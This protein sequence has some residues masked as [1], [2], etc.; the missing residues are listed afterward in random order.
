MPLMHRIHQHRLANGLWLVAEPIAEVQ[1]LAMSLLL[2][3]GVS[4]EPEHQQGAATMLSEMICRGAGGLDARAHSD[5]LD[6]L[7]VQRGT[8]V[9]TH[10]LRLSAAMIADKLPQALPLLMDMVR[11]PLLADDALEPTRDLSLQSLEALEDEPQQK[12][13]IALRRQHHPQPFGRSPMGRRE[14]LEAMTLD[15]VR[16]F[17]RRSFVPD[18]AVLSFAGKLD[19][20][21]LRERV[22]SLLGDWT[23]QLA[24]P[25]PTAPA[26]RGYY[27]ENAPSTQVHIGLAYDAPPET[28]PSS[29]LQRAAVA[30]L[31]GGMS[32]RLF[33]QVRERRGLV[34]SVFARYGSDRRRGSVFSY[35]G[36]T[37]PRAQE[38]LQVLTDELRGLAK[39][40]EPDEFQRAI[41][42]MKA[43]LVMQGES[44]S[45]R[46][47]AIA[48][49]QYLLDH[50]RT[51]E[52]VSAQVDALTLD[53]VV[54][55]VTEHPPGAM[56]TVT[57][58]PEPLQAL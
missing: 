17:W 49:D 8:G 41:V 37:A 2:P 23:G 25:E 39:G 21:E 18:G 10:H 28:D 54:R 58:G 26:T 50:P 48:A 29:M 46:A 43:G 15:H 20:T 44:T 56:T 9:D 32:G 7:G 6:H 52:E 51:L 13:F 47:G 5:A 45:A 31:S 4:L 16:A 55:F 35:A 14:D 19:W 36:T 1:S 22:E 12:V 40:I 27:H 42:G 53:E 30:V 38:T 3:A 11:R 34:Y 57:I 33:T 24:S